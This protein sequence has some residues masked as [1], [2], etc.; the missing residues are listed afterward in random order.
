MLR[1]EIF[2]RIDDVLLDVLKFVNR[3]DLCDR[4]NVYVRLN[5]V[6]VAVFVLEHTSL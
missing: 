4:C 3:V 5:W 6:A 2:D 1:V